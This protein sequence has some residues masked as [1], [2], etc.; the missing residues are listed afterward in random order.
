MH[1]VPLA[2]G[3][4]LA[5]RE[6]LVDGVGGEHH[7]IKRLVRHDALGGVH[8]AHRFDLHLH[9]RTLF[10]GRHQIGQHL[11]RGHGRNAADRPGRYVGGAGG[12]KGWHEPDCAQAPENH[13]RHT[14][15]L[16]IP[17]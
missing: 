13:K 1:Q 15:L 11:A 2:A 3:H 8:A 5:R 7:Q 9:A 6:Q 4:E 12:C 16:A 17:F 14:V 10:V